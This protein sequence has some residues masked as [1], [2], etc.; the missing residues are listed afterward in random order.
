MKLLPC[1][2][3]GGDD[4]LLTAD[5]GQSFL[6]ALSSIIE[7]SNDEE[8]I[9]AAMGI[10]S[11]LPAGYDKFTQWLLDAEALKSIIKFLADVRL[12]GLSKNPIL[13]NAVGA[14]CFFTVSTNHE[15]QRRAAE[16]GVIPMLVQLLG[17]GTALTKIYAAICLAQFSESSLSLSRPIDKPKFFLCCS[18]P[19]ELGCAVHLGVCSVETSFCLLEA[20]A[21]KPLVR[22][23]GEED[24]TV[25]EA[26]LKAVA[27]LL[28][29]EMLERGSRVIS[30]SEGIGP[31]IRLLTYHETNLQE[32]ALR[33]LDKI[34]QLEEHKKMHG[35]SAQMPLVD[36]A[37]RGSGKIRALAARV[38]AHLDVLHDQ[39]S[40]F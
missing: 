40:Y 22:L 14:L 31:V 34:F 15:S 33:V 21:V 37:Q 4:S 39:S 29:G 3:E 24:R 10:I 38:L 25:C 36:I 32:K 16:A 13:E 7:T 30:A 19:P 11:K 1:L 23:L 27:T 18:T 6:K 26:S 9:A 2:M 8:E 17:S 28:E 5:A 12:V 20:D 35:V